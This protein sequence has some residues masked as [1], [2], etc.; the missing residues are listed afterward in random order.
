MR[1]SS[2]VPNAPET[3]TSYTSFSLRYVISLLAVV[4]AGGSW[5]LMMGASALPAV[6]HAVYVS[7]LP[8][9]PRWLLR[10][11]DAA[12]ATRSR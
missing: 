6:A 4:F 10:R 3:R 11:G 1:V 9:S 12:A 8:E 2:R 7:A 5:R